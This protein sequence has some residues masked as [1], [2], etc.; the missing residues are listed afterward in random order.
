MM[1]RTAFEIDC[2]PVIPECGFAC[3][4]CIEEIAT[5][6]AGIDGITKVVMGEGAEEGK[7]IVEYDSALA[8][9]GQLLGVLKTLPSFYQ[10][11]FIPTAI[12]S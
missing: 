4:Q 8:T 9:V 6:L 7:V 3:P 12:P 10:G 11:F 2:R 5:T 1:T